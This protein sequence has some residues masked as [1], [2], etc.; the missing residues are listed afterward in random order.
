MLGF[1]SK[2]P[3]FRPWGRHS[4]KSL[5]FGFAT[6]LAIAQL[7]PGIALRSAAALED[8]KTGLAEVGVKAELGKKIDLGLRFT[9]DSGREVTLKELFL[10]NRPLIIVPAYYGCPRLCGL[11]LNGVSDLLNQIELV[12]GSDFTVATVS[13]NPRNTAEDA[14]KIAEEFRAK[15]TKGQESS[16]S[17]HFLA[18]TKENIDPLMHSLG[19]QYQPDGEDFSHTA[20]I[21]LITPSGELS[22]YMAGISFDGG[23]VRRALVEASAGSIGTLMDQVFLFCFRYDHLQGKYV[24]AALGAQR[25]GGVLTLSF[26]VWLIYRLWARERRTRGASP[27]T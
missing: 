2:Y 3:L 15:L 7:F 1:F 6:F 21:F 25:I 20:A 14:A 26:L 9:D 18:G 16:K 12:L 5:V 8:P 24:W 4:H 10:P 27:A 19:F 23:V 13:F 17:W 11:L 22:Q